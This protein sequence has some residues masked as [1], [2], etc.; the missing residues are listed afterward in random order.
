MGRNT[1]RDVL[2]L[3]VAAFLLSSCT[4]ADPGDVER[5]RYPHW[6]KGA[7]APETADFM[8][9]DVPAGASEVKGAV[10]VNPQEDVYLLSFVT[11][12]RAAVR[13]AEELHPEEPLH[14]K[15]VDL[16]PN[17]EQFGHLSLPEPQNLKG[18]RWAGVC[19]PCVGDS[20][21]RNVAW[22][23]IY[24]HDITEGQSRVYLKAF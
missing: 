10:E 3:L 15:T 22:I 12:E 4:V 16:P 8:K 7:G 17:R 5:V 21:R 11:S 9:V 24:V 6:K 19:P 18:A 2:L 14:T 1:G 23:D 13:I 20:K